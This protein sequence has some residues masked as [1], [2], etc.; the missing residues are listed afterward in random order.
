MA[1]PAVRSP[2]KPRFPPLV[3]PARQVGSK[4]GK[5]SI[6]FSGAEIGACEKRFEHSVIAKFTVGR[7]RLAE[8][9]KAFQSSWA[10]TGRVSIS[11]V[12]DSRHLLVIFD[13]EDDVRV[14][15]ASSLNKV[16]HALFRRFRWHPDYNPKRESATST[17]WVR[18][19]GLPISIYDPAFI[20]AI[21]STFGYF[22]AV[23]DRTKACTDLN[24]AR[25][26]VELDVTKGI[27]EAVWINMPDD[28]SYWQ[29]VKVDSKIAYC[30]KCR[31][32]GHNFES[33]RKRK[34]S[35]PVEAKEENRSFLREEP[36]V[37][38]GNFEVPLN[39][40][41]A[42]KEWREVVSRKRKN[43]ASIQSRT[44]G[45]SLSDK[46]KVEVKVAVETPADSSLEGALVIYDKGGNPEAERG[47][48]RMFSRG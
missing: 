25:A 23:D 26:C 48:L 27:P 2:F 40:D 47:W 35:K 16:G 18:L 17:I 38:K 8:I 45:G 24:S 5:P 31:L 19:P 3:L 12:W 43:K 15:L 42:E 9:Q 11:A 32:H 41:G 37:V 20:K 6:C 34:T 36:N 13:S 22:V 7:P 33:C 21:L 14:A 30:S 39:K 4:E 10:T 46:G 29:V 44:V 1:G 28:R